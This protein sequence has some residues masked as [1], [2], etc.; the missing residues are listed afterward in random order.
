[1]PKKKTSSTSNEVE[2]DVTEANRFLS[3]VMKDLPQGG[4]FDKVVCGSVGTHLALTNSIPYVIVV[5]FVE[6]I[7]SKI[8]QPSY[9]DVYVV[10]GDASITSRNKPENLK[11]AIKSGT[12][13]KFLVTYASF[14]KLVLSLEDKAK[15]F[16]LL[17]DEAHMLTAADDK[18]YMHVHIRKILIHY[19]K[20]KS[21]CFMTSTPYD[22]EC[23][24]DELNHL[25]MYRAKW[26]PLVPV[27]LIAQQIKQ[28][29][30][31]YIAYIALEHLQGKRP[32]SA[33]FF[34][35]SIEGIGAVV[36]K[37]LNFCN[38]NEIRII[39]SRKLFEDPFSVNTTPFGRKKK[40]KG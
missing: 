10:C 33:F 21:F 1:M 20:F 19:T 4:F 18:N 26:K 27:S 8:S 22:R 39:A 38:V 36:K 15:N 28:N 12:V 32:G 31:N 30:N 23:I 14:E 29:F 17:V 40:K 24:P 9:N 3:E 37:L 16:Q 35:N 13:K 34:F 25:P 11:A 5:P 2:I 6:I 7:R